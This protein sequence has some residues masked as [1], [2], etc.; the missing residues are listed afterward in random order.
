MTVTPINQARL[1]RVKM[2]DRLRLELT[3]LVAEMEQQ[4]PELRKQCDEWYQA[5]GQGCEHI[6][7]MQEDMIRDTK[8]LLEGDLKLFLLLVPEPPK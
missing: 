2:S 7:A 6:F 8:D 1:N 4:L 5:T 3:E